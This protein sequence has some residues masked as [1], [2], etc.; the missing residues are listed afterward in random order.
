MRLV[1]HTLFLKA[2]TVESPRAHGRLSCFL[3]F[4]LVALDKF[5]DKLRQ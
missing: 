3:N 4:E 1:G 2:I 5:S